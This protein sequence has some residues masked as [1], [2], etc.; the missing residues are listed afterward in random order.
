MSGE[1]LKNGLEGLR[2]IE[3]LS[4]VLFDGIYWI[5]V[6]CIL[7]FVAYIIS[8]VNC[9]VNRKKRGNLNADSDNFLGD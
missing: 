2:K 7:L 6:I 3:D 1:D 5:A 4:D 9:Y 8:V